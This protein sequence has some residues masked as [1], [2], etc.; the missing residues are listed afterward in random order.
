MPREM[1]ETHTYSLQQLE[2][3]AKS[4]AKLSIVGSLYIG[5]FGGQT[6]EWLADGFLRVLTTH[7]PGSIERDNAGS[8]R[9]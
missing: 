8:Y 2:E 7:T 6:V 9:R 3:I 4:V 5:D 1:T